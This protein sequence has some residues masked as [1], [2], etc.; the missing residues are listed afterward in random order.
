MSWTPPIELL[1]ESFPEVDWYKMLPNMVAGPVSEGILLVV[2]EHGI[3]G[4][5]S[6]LAALVLAKELEPSKGVLVHGTSESTPALAVKSLQDRI[7]LLSDIAPSF[8][9]RIS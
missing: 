1:R 6:F 9:S 8:N 5:G 3:P 7:A 4:F 2:T